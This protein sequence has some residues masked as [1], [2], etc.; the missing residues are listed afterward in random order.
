[1]EGKQVSEGN[2]VQRELTRERGS[3]VKFGVS[4]CLKHINVTCNFYVNLY[5]CF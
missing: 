2:N 3:F 4:Y 5:S 1:M